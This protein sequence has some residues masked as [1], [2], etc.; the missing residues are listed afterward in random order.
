MLELWNAVVLTIFD[1]VFG[2]LRGWSPDLALVV[3]SLASAFLLTQVRRWT[4]PQDL[5]RRIARDRRRLRELR[6]EAKRAGDR[7]AVRRARTL[8]G[9]IGLRA[10]RC[11]GRPLL[12]AI[13]PVLALATWCFE[14]LDF[15]TTQLEEP[16]ELA[17]D[18][19][20]SAVG[21]VVHLVP[22]EGLSTKSWVS[23]VELEDDGLGRAVWPLYAEVGIAREALTVRFGDETIVHPIGW[24]RDAPGPERVEH[25]GEL[26]THVRLTPVDLWGVVPAFPSLGIL[27]WMIGYVLVILP[28]VWAA[29]RVLGIY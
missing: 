11:E 2:W 8:L 17:L 21:E 7:E 6:R 18:T 20:R 15:R 24:G 16:T 12:V 1:V 9:V 14:R 4:T 22:Q 27:P 19:P 10:I 25:E 5:L 23:V 29:K 26:T 28:G 3:V 13:V